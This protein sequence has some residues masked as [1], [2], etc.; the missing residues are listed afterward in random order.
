MIKSSNISIKLSL[1][2]E[3]TKNGTQNIAAKALIKNYYVNMMML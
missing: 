2:S 1:V 3:L